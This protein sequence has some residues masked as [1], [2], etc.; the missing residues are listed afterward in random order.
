MDKKD[1]M[2]E[3]FLASIMQD[4]AKIVAA[5][6]KK[7]NEASVRQTGSPINNSSSSSTKEY[8]MEQI[9]SMEQQIN[10]IKSIIGRM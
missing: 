9:T 10:H 3:D 6:D 2:S 4:S 5:E 1:I 8:L 7:L